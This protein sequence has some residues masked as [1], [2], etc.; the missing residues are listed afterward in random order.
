MAT[1]KGQVCIVGIGN[2]SGYDE[3]Q[4]YIRAITATPAGPDQPTINATYSTG[5]GAATQ[6][7]SLE[8]EEVADL[9]LNDDY[10]RQQ[11]PTAVSDSRPFTNTRPVQGQIVWVAIYDATEEEHYFFLAFVRAIPG[12]PSEPEPNL[13]VSYLDLRDDS[14]NNANQIEPFSTAA[15][16]DDYWFDFKGNLE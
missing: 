7:N 14:D 3:H 12:A 16:T 9:G 5:T 6:I 8:N 10:W 2:G 1:E 15:P 4:G 13:N 11:L